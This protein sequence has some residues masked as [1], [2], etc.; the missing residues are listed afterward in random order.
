MRT[1]ELETKKRDRSREVGGGG[2]NANGKGRKKS[3]GSRG[4]E[5]MMEGKGVEWNLIRGTGGEM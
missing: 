4:G 5:K 1:A 2:G 3:R